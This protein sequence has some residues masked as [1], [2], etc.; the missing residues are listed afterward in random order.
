VSFTRCAIS[1]SAHFGANPGWA[2]SEEK[3]N[4]TDKDRLQ[5]LDRERHEAICDAVVQRLRD[6][7]VVVTDKFHEAL[8][9]AIE[10]NA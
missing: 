1:C 9:E 7:G 10:E 5:K 6:L 4:D 3:M 2:F 8:W